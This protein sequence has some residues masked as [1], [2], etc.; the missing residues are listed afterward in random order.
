MHAKVPAWGDISA[1]LP[2]MTLPRGGL[3]ALGTACTTVFDS[4]KVKPFY[5]L[6]D[7]RLLVGENVGS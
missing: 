1:M 6:V 5:L 2:Y 7:P 3:Y 4:D